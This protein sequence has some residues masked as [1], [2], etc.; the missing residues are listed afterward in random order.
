MPIPGDLTTITVTASYPN[1]AGQSQTGHVSFDPGQP[2]ADSTGKVI[3]TGKQC[4]Y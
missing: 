3:L 2:V 1:I 4:G